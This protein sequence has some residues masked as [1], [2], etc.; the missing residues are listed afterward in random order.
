MQIITVCGIRWHG[1]KNKAVKNFLI[2]FCF[3]A[4]AFRFL[5]SSEDEIRQLLE[6]K[7]SKNTKR[8]NKVAQQGFREYLL[9]KRLQS[10]PK[11]ATLLG[12]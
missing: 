9:E 11:K 5:S 1:N 2:F 8:T 7:A 4:M 3:H 12:F 6:G 10:Q